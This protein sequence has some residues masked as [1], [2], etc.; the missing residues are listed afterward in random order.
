MAAMAEQA[1]DV[2]AACSTCGPWLPVLALSSWY[3][4]WAHARAGNGS[5]SL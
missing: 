5:E 1:W 2:G 4:R 3:S